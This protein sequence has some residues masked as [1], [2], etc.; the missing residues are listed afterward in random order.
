MQ[1]YAA[2]DVRDVC[3]AVLRL[4]R[5]LSLAVGLNGCSRAQTGLAHKRQVYGLL[6]SGILRP[7][8]ITPLQGMTIIA[9]WMLFSRSRKISLSW[10]SCGIFYAYER[11][12]RIYRKS[13]HSC[14]AQLKFL[15]RCS[16]LILAEK[17]RFSDCHDSWGGYLPR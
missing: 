14:K 13:S 4:R 1:L 10:P 2:N 11:H 3:R 9:D 8:C 17:F 7:E 6:A 5:C 16:C 15:R 12:L